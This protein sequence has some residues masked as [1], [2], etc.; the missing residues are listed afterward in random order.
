MLF[1]QTRF[2]HHLFKARTIVNRESWQRSILALP[3]RTFHGTPS[4]FGTNTDALSD[5]LDQKYRIDRG[6]HSGIFKALQSVHGPKIR[7]EHFDAFGKSGLEALAASVQEQL[8]KRQG[9]PT[10][11]STMLKVS[12]P[13]HG[14][15][16]ELKWRL[17]DTVL[18]V[19]QENE[20]LMAEYME[21]SC[22]GIMSCCTCHIYIDQ[23]EFQAFL[24]EPDE[25]ELDMLV[26]WK[27]HPCCTLCRA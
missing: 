23:P 6:L 25:S 12:V 8:K 20:D 5:Y 24:G 7:I 17:G 13:H 9:R 18:E 22:G 14:T 21:G 26:S 1:P 10:R 16:F 2:C 19:A 3:C 27:T 4:R 15:S 11:P